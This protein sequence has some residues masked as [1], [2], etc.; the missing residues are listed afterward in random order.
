MLKSTFF[1][2]IFSVPQ[3]PS[4]PF[5]K[6]KKNTIFISAFEEIAVLQLNFPKIALFWFLES[7]V[8]DRVPE[9]GFSVSRNVEQGFSSL[10]PPKFWPI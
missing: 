9:I 3:D 4:D 8:T 2:N 10:S 1:S 7:A 5:E 6:I